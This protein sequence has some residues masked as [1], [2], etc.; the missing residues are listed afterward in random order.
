MRKIEELTA[1]MIER[2]HD[3]LA[4]NRIDD[5]ATVDDTIMDLEIVVALLRHKR[6]L[7]AT[8]GLAREPLQAARI[9][10]P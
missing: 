10:A 5:L 8:P 6:Q 4:A 3:V 7:Q 1:L 9:V 2:C